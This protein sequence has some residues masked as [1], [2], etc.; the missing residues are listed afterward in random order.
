MSKP[1][2]SKIY[3]SNCGQLIPE[4]SNFC[5]YCGAAQHGTQASI[6]HASSAPVSHNPASYIQQTVNKQSPQH[7][8][9]YIKRRKLC[10]E[11]KWSFFMAYVGSTAI[12]PLLFIVGAA[13]YPI[14][15]IAALLVY[16]L[17]IYVAA[18]AVYDSFYY[19]LDETGFQ[20]EYGIINKISVSIPYQQIQNVNI[21]R[22]LADRMLGLSRINIETA[23]SSATQTREVAGGSKSKAEGHLPGL[24]LSEAKKVH[25]FLLE[26]A[27][28]YRNNQG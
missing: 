19:A 18:T 12:L 25:D 24:R 2:F 11:V 8:I 26:Q 20:K 23:G 15:F 28:A 22:S 27:N 7:K 1:L 4:D 5:R 10:K 9:Q 14:I 21:T 3:C 6:Y 17:T 16:F 13:I